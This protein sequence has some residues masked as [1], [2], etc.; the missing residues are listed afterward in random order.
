VDVAEGDP[1]SYTINFVVY[2]SITA[3]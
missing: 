2:G 1:N 3:T